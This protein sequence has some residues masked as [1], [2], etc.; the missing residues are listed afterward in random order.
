MKF[1]SQPD[2]LFHPETRRN[3]DYKAEH[4]QLLNEATTLLELAL[5]KWEA[6]LDELSEVS[7]RYTW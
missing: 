6:K 3:G 5:W 2:N 4:N 7:E 1:C